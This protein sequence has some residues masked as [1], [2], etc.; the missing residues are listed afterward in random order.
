MGIWKYKLENDAVIMVAAPEVTGAY[1]YQRGVYEHK[2]FT[3]YFGMDFL[4]ITVRKDYA[5]DGCTPK[6]KLGGKIFGVWDGFFN[7]RTKRPDTYYASLVHDVLLQF[8]GEHP[9]SRE[10]ADNIFLWVMQRDDFP[11]AWIY[12]AFVRLWYYVV[13]RPQQILAP[14]RQ[15]WLATLNTLL[16]RSVSKK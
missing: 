7:H 1:A 9:I 15:K 14:W 8:L 6:F 2:W 16:N 11:F 13:R 12:Y 5:W 4:M 3:L 10:H